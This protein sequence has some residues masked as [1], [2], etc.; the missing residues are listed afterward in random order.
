MRSTYQELLLRLVWLYE[1]RGQYQHSIERFKELV[2]RD[3]SNEEAHRQ[4]MRLYTLTGNKH[5]ALRQYQVCCDALEKE[6]DAE[7]DRQG[8][9]SYLGQ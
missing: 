6:L 9:L 2:A 1:T 4:L 5:Q 8:G 3:Q 7:P